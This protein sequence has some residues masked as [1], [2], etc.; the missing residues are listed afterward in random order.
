MHESPALQHTPL[1]STLAH[2]PVVFPPFAPPLVDPFPPPGV[3]P[4]PLVATP[5]PVPL[6]ELPPVDPPHAAATTTTPNRVQ[7]FT[8]ASQR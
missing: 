7:V 8:T 2:P 6:P 4:P 3:P 1:H 5:P